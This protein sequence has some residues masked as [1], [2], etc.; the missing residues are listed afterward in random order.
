MRFL[1]YAIAVILALDRTI[2][3]IEGPTLAVCG[4]EE[5]V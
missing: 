5:L 2:A 4:R 3:L 1:L